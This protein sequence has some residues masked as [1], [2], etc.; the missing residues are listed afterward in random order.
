MSSTN[1]DYVETYFENPVLTKIHGEPTYW[2][3]K[4]IKDELKSNA[5]AVTTE[6]GGGAHGH[7]GLV[8]TPAEYATVLAVPYVRPVHPGALVIAPGTTQHETSRLR[9]EHKKAIKLC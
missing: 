1:I 2:T 9:E 4:L 7:L 5:S 3:L 8:L 6:I